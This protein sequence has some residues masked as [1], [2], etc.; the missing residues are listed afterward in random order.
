MDYYRQQAMN[1]VPLFT[2]TS[3]KWQFDLTELDGGMIAI[4][5][6]H[7]RDASYWEVYDLP[8]DFTQTPFTAFGAIYPSVVVE[9]DS[10][11]VD[12]KGEG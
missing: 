8:V 9:V 3:E 7:T 5:E 11:V 4:M 10:E 2:K 6:Q 1:H 12:E